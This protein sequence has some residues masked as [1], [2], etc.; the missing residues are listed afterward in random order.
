MPSCIFENIYF[1]QIKSQGGILMLKDLK[2]LIKEL[3][4]IDGVS[5]DEGNIAN[6]LSSK[7]NLLCDDAF[8]DKNGNVIGSIKAKN[9]S[10]IRT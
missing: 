9:P 5:A 8:I 2:K 3:T 7:L 6:T 1:Y 10:K 4:Y